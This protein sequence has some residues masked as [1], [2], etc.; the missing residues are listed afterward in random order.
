MA[1]T[2]T[3]SKTSV[4]KAGMDKMWA[5][6]LTLVITDDDGPGFTKTFSQNYKQGNAIPDFQEKFNVDMQKAIDDYKAEQ[7]LFKHA[8]LDTLVT[9]IQSGLEVD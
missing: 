3:V 7:A 1:L 9:D 8:H 6:T 5:L 2:K 4:R